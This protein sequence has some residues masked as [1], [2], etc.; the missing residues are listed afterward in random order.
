[1]ERFE[2]LHHPQKRVWIVLKKLPKSS[3]L[4][5]DRKEIGVYVYIHRCIHLTLYRGQLK[6]I[7]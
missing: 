7:W 5:P 2:Y 4:Y 1:M 3:R 6:G